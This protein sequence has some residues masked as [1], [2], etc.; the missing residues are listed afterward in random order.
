MIT[1]IEVSA[2]VRYWEDAVIKGVNDK[3]GTLTPFRRGD[4]WCPVIRLADGVVMDWPAGMEAVFHFKVCDAGEYWLLDEN[5][6]RVAKW[7]GYYVPDKFL[8]P[9]GAGYGDYIILQVNAEG[10]INKWRSGGPDIVFEGDEPDAS[11]WKRLAPPPAPAPAKDPAIGR[12]LPL[13]RCHKIVR[14]A[15]ITALR[16]NGNH[17]MPDLVLGDIGGIVTLLPDWHAKHKP[18]VGGYLVQYDDG[19]TSFSPAKAFEEGYTRE[20]ADYRERVRRELAER[21]GEL[22]RLS[23]FCCG[24][25]FSSLSDRQQQL[26]GEQRR[27]MVDLVN[28]L[29]RRIAAFED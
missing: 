19:Y 4:D 21:T 25:S 29:A 17:D 26:M 27:V 6:Q 13:Y 12:D 22:D 3:D 15:K 14:A 5:R 2:A 11:S 1:Y 7:S 28:V 20:P 18:Q 9:A 23:A 24:P 16:Q 8:C 10:G